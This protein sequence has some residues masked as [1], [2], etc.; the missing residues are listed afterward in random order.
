MEFCT[1][2]G[3]VMITMNIS[4]NY[5]NT[6]SISK[7]ELWEETIQVW[8]WLVENNYKPSDFTCGVIQMHKEGF[9]RLASKSDNLVSVKENRVC[10]TSAVWQGNVEICLIEFKSNV[11]A[12]WS[13]LEDWEP[14]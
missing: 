12:G 6:K 5:V 2:K 1:S 7:R 13:L 8:D 14:L 11:Q 3:Q 10:R 9:A 4:P